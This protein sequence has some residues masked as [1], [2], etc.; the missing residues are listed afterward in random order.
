M[1][2]RFLWERGAR[3]RPTLFAGPVGGLCVL[4]AA[5]GRYITGRFLPDKAIDLMD[6]ACANV[7]CQLDSQP[8][9]IDQLE[10]KRSGP[11]P[12]MRSRARF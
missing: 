8:E 12:A 3:G 11:A 4:I 2:Q 6:E 7:R 10:R 1:L 9:I 5:A